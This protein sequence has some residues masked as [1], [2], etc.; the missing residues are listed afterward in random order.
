[1]QNK[2]S[3][4]DGTGK[5]KI[6]KYE[7]TVEYGYPNEDVEVGDMDLEESYMAKKSDYASG[8]QVNLWEKEKES[9]PYTP[10]Q[11]PNPPGT[12]L[13]STNGTSV[14]Y[15]INFKKLQMRNYFQGLSPGSTADNWRDWRHR[16]VSNKL[17]R[18]FN[19]THRQDMRTYYYEQKAIHDALAPAPT[20]TPEDGQ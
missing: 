17:Y 7:I 3:G 19:E 12:A 2:I 5:K 6:L 8:F 16:N 11:V 10:V 4:E 20:P 18:K 14:D 13:P 9:D 1:M 15:L